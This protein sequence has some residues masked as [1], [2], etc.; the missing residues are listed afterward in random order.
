MFQSVIPRSA[1]S[2][3]TLAFS[4]FDDHRPVLKSAECNPGQGDPYSGEFDGHIHGPGF[5]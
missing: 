5:V 3:S 2:F 1:R 4:F